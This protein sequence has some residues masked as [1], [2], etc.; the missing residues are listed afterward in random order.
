MMT[1]F[2]KVMV[3]F[4]T[5]ASIAFL[6]VALAIRNTGPSWQEETQNLP[7]YGFTL[8][9]GENPQWSAQYRKESAALATT[10]SLPDAIGKAYVHGTQVNQT[11]FDAINPQ[12]EPIN[13]RIAQLKQYV[14]V[15]EQGL[16]KREERL[17]QTLQAVEAE[18][19]RVSQEG[20]RF[21]TQ[22]VDIRNDA[23]RTRESG[24]RL[25]R[26]REQIETDL[27]RLTEEKRQ[28]LDLIYQME[29]I[30]QRLRDRNKQLL[31]AGATPVDSEPPV[32]PSTT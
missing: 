16:K 10:N 17:V 23:E 1:K 20:E 18:I 26:Q 11:E 25:K 3:V 14:T 30:V 29:G 12:I 4:V 15:D 21:A 9:S 13:Q 28:L 2:A 19:E 8:G 27:Y 6:G 5:T 22:A 24:M 32:G 31:D 7:E